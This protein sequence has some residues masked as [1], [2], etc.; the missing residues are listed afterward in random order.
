MREKGI[1]TLRVNDPRM[2]RLRR[3]KVPVLVIVEMPQADGMA[4]LFAL[5]GMGAE[6]MPVRRMKVSPL[7]RVGL[8][9]IA[10]RLLISELIKL[11]ED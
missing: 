2:I 9:A 7:T 6:M 8:S 11:Y 1:V 4:L 10:A 5:P 3:V